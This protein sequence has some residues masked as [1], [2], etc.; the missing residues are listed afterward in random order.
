MPF[1]WKEKR[2]AELVN[3]LANFARTQQGFSIALNGFA[4][5]PPRVIYLDVLNTP[6]LLSLQKELT[7]SLRRELGIHHATHKDNG[8]VPHLTVAFRDLKKGAFE[9]A[10]ERVSRLEEQ[11]EYVQEDVSLLKHDGN[12][13]QEFQK[14]HFGKR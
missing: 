6:P 10:W 7:R 8:F 9:L 4:A 5:F 13:W 11:H 2:E 1:R 12:G 14:F 3:L